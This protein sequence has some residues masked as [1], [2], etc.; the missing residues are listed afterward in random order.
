MRHKAGKMDMDILDSI[1]DQILT[2]ASGD[3]DVFQA[4]GQ[5]IK[6]TVNLPADGFVIGE[7]PGTGGWVILKRLNSSLPGCSG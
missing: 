2:Q 6:D 1:I 4:F 5:L 3:D 7:P